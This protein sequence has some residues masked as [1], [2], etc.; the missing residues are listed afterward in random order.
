MN[1]LSEEIRTNLIT[2]TETFSNLFS[3]LVKKLV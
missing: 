3:Y 1:S 2:E